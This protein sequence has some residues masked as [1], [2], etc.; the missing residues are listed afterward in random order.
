MPLRNRSASFWRIGGSSKTHSHSLAALL[1]EDSPLVRESTSCAKKPVRAVGHCKAGMSNDHFVQIN[2]SVV[3]VAASQREETCVRL[4]MKRQ[5]MGRMQAGSKKSDLNKD[6]LD[7]DDTG[8]QPMFL[9]V[10]PAFIMF[11]MLTVK[12]DK[13]LDSFPPVEYYI[14][15][16]RIG[17]SPFTQCHLDTLHHCMRVIR[18]THDHGTYPKIVFVS[19]HKDFEHKFQQESRK[20]ELNRLQ[21]IILAINVKTPEKEE[22]HKVKPVEIPLRCSPLEMVFQQMAKEQQNS[23]LSKEECFEVAK[24]V[25]PTIYETILVGIRKALNSGHQNIPLHPATISENGE[26]LTCTTHC[27]FIGSEVTVQ[28]R[29]WLRSSA[30]PPSPKNTG[31]Y[32]VHTT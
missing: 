31:I 2:D 9:D 16:V 5:Y 12:L 11:G 32:N 21:S 17:D 23:V 15:E 8:G 24:G 1:E 30:V 3:K 10:L 29:L 18:S 22:L 20:M 6:L 25:C 13:S 28:H 14:N 27:G 26:L 4:T 19:T 7:I